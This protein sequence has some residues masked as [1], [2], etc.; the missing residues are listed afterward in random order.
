MPSYT[1]SDTLAKGENMDEKL[2]R[3][4]ITEKLAVHLDTSA[5]WDAFMKLLEKD[6]AVTSITWAGGENPTEHPNLW[7]RYDNDTCIVYCGNL[8]YSPKEF[9]EDSGYLIIE[10]KDLIKE[11]EN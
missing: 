7:R 10:F 5:E 1:H 6:N 9:Y 4:F 3:Q 8:M 2:F 11:E